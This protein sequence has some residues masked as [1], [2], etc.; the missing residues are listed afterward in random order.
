MAKNGAE[1]LV[2]V[3]REEWPIL[4]YEMDICGAADARFAGLPDGPRATR[5]C[6]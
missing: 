4:L 2:E 1:G 6:A 3:L 5:T